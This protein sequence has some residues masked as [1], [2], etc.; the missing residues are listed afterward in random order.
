MKFS[1]T[2]FKMIGFSGGTLRVLL[3][4]YSMF[5]YFLFQ[6]Q[7]VELQGSSNTLLFMDMQAN[8][9]P[10]YFFL[11]IP[12]FQNLNLT[13]NGLQLCAWEGREQPVYL[14]HLERDQIYSILF[15]FIFFMCTP[16]NF[17]TEQ[18]C[19]LYNEYSPYKFA[20]W[21]EILAHRVM[22][23]CIEGRRGRGAVLRGFSVVIR[24]SRLQFISSY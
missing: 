7:Y 6:K 19:A 23:R 17:P 22:K 13:F 12:A 5:S 11:Y 2:G 24:T 9:A 18:E 21:A 16:C 10:S 20:C 14:K 1:L 15:Y 4:K 3:S 8:L